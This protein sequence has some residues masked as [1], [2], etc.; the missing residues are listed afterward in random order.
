M[1][2]YFVHATWQSNCVSFFVSLE[3][4]IVFKI[5]KGISE[6]ILKT[7]VCSICVFVWKSA[8]FSLTFLYIRLLG[9]QPTRSWYICV[10]ILVF[11]RLLSSLIFLLVRH[12]RS[13]V[14][15]INVKMLL[16]LCL[17]I[18]YWYLTY[19]QVRAVNGL[20]AVSVIS[21]RFMY[22]VF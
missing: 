22:F 18:L 9:E 5:L 3:N 19:A 2:V 1:N 15:R 21:K 13:L 16:F 4:T 12:T 7:D 8:A 17:I 20:K 14:R 6:I 10:Q 11:E